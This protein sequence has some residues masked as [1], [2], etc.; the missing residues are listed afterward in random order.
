MAS[1]SRAAQRTEGPK[2]YIS[3]PLVAG[4]SIRQRH[5]YWCN[6]VSTWLQCQQLSVCDMPSCDISWL[7]GRACGKYFSAH[8]ACRY[9]LPYAMML[10]MNEYDSTIAH[11]VVHA[12]Q[13]CL[14]PEALMSY[15]GESFYIM[16]RLACGFRNQMT[17][18]H[19]YSVKRARAVQRLLAPVKK[20]FDASGVR[21]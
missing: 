7:G 4:K 20:L 2:L 10:G 6:R 21:V 18:T 12:Y 8:H 11:E 5:D 3:D 9:Y 16:M 19:S 14:L 17:H 13:R 1:P 15:H